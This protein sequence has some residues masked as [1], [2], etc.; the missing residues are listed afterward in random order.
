[1]GLVAEESDH[2]LTVD[3]L[4]D[5]IAA[6][7]RRGDGLGALF[8]TG[9]KHLERHEEAARRTADAIALLLGTLALE[10]VERL[11]RG[12][13][14]DRAGKRV[15]ADFLVRKAKGSGELRNGLEKSLRAGLA[16]NVLVDGL[17]FGGKR[18]VAAAFLGGVGAAVNGRVKVW[19]RVSLKDLTKVG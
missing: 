17:D 1:V 11:V 6:R 18:V 13:S 19:V 14:V 3:G 8:A 16:C 2:V 7:A 15:A 5:E 9:R 12:E 10:A 4:A